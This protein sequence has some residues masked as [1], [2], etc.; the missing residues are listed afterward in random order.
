MAT[1]QKNIKHQNP[2]AELSLTQRLATVETNNNEGPSFEHFKGT[3]FDLLVLIKN[4]ML[5]RFFVR[6][7]TRSTDQVSGFNRPRSGGSLKVEGRMKDEL[8]LAKY[9]RDPRNS[10]THRK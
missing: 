4:W 9:T 5:S 10:S 6:T 8:G 7:S 3:I 2:R 1:P